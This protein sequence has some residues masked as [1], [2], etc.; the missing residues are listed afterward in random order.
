MKELKAIEILKEYN[1]NNP[2][3][4]GLKDKL[5]RYNKINLTDNQVLYINHNKDFVVKGINK[6]IQISDFLAESYK[7]EHNFDFLPVRLQVNYF[8]G[9]TEKTYH[10]YAKFTKKQK[11]FS[12]LWLPKTQ[13]IDDFTV[14][15]TIYDKDD[16]IVINFNKY[17][18]LDRLKRTPFKHQEEGVKFLLNRTGAILGYGMGTGKTFI[19]IVSA[20][21]LKAK[22]IL[23][24]CPASLKE[25]WRNEIECFTDDV[26]VIE[27]KKW[28]SKKFT[29]INYDILQNFHT[30]KPKNLSKEDFVFNSEFVN[31]KFDLIICDEAHYLKTYSA[32]RTQVCREFLSKLID[33][34]VW[35]LTGTPVANNPLDFY[36]LLQL[37][38]APISKNYKYFVKRYCDGKTINKKLA[39][40]RVK[41]IHLTNGSSNLEELALKVKPFMQRKNLQDVMDMPDRVITPLYHKL[42]NK[43]LAEYESLWEN[44]LIERQNLNKKGTPDKQLVELILLRKF[45]SMVN[46]QNTIELTKNAIEEGHKVVIFCSFTEELNF[47]YNEFKSIGVMHNGEMTSK[48]KQNSVDK[49]Q[50]DEKV[51]VFVGN[52]ISSGTGITLTKGTVSIFNSLDWTPANIQQAI[53]RCYRIGQDKKVNIYFNITKDTVDEKIWNRLY[54]KSLIINT[55]ND[56]KD[57]ENIFD[58]DFIEN[59]EEYIDEL[60]F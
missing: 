30:I 23:I 54:E 47:I 36:S 12:E 8:L 34:R 27:G 14:D 29:V 56:E 18:E 16:D 9:E 3:L 22:K 51:K 48:E 13:V 32:I 57:K 24:I 26:C 2:Y 39:N 5:L 50:N 49:F 46:I 1:G 10:V 20:L 41:K 19:S 53:F 44:Y 37:I 28:E 35:L 42:N 25:N 45:M 59:A 11:H 40:G 55:I 17:K 43:Q 7:K 38:N 21:E 58:A 31:E 33:K 52:I 15:N 4:H 6:V 60:L